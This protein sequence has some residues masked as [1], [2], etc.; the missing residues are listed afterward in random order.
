MAGTRLNA[1]KVVE[2]VELVVVDDELV[3]L[4]LLTDEPREV[5]EP[6]ESDETCGHPAA[7]AASTTATSTNPNPLALKPVIKSSSH[8]QKSLHC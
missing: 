5:D 1:G 7:A 3:L 8:C 6:P 2:V 4:E